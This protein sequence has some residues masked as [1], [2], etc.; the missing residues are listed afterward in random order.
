MS[1]QPQLPKPRGRRTETG[2]GPNPTV[3][4]VVP[5]KDG[6]DEL[7][8]CLTALRASTVDPELHE[9]L[10]VDDGSSDDS[11]AV[12]REFGATVLRF[13]QNRGPAFARNRGAELARGQILFFCDA[14]VEVHPDTIERA[15][16]C[17]VRD[18][19]LAA[20]IGS[21][22]EA[23]G[24][25]HFIAQFKNLFH[26]WVHQHGSEDASTFWTGCGAVRR[27]TFLAHGGFDETFAR[28]SIEDIELGFRLRADGQKIRLEKEMQAKHLKRWRLFDLLRTDIFLRGAPW[29]ALMLRDRHLSADLNLSTGSKLATLLTGVLGITLVGLPVTGHA[30][31]LLPFATLIVLATLAARVTSIFGSRRTPVAADLAF[32]T[33][34]IATL[35]ASFWFAGDAFALIPFALLSA[36]MSTHVSLHADFLRQRGFTFILAAGPMQLLYQMCCA[37][38]VPVGFL[39][40]LRSESRDAQ[41]SRSQTEEA[42]A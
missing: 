42:R 26:H 24:S 13:E 35:S 17:F 21:Y 39:A 32:A 18:Q 25:P 8:R 20:V 5:V 11:S 14:D 37:L 38:S 27:D 30:M 2:L 23:P 28:P 7:R 12:A 4:T 41:S 19:D 3:T 29:V 16:A 22:D 31:A 15:R 36:T 9:L 33:F 40:H 1:P 34:A 10:V 6:A